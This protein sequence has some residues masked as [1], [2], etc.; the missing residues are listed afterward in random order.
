MSNSTVSDN[1]APVGGGLAND[2]NATGP[3]NIKNSI[4]AK[5]TLGDDCFNAAIFLA[6]GANLDTDGSCVAA[7]AS[8]NFAQVTSSQLNLGPLS[9]NAPGSTKTHALLSGSV[10]ID[11]ASDCTDFFNDPVTTDQRGVS[12]PQGMACD[13]GAYEREP[14]ALTSKVN[15]RFHYSANG[16]AGG[17]SGTKTVGPSGAVT[18]GPQAMGGNLIVQPG[19]TLRVGYDFTMPGSHPETTLAFTQTMVTFQALCA[20]G[21][22]GGT[23]V[24]SIQNRTYTDPQNSSA[25][26][27][28]GNQQDPSV[29]QASTI[30]PDFCGGGALS[31]REGAAFSSKVGSL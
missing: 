15:V 31:L 16:S 6:A 26:Y 3:M 13:I 11:A 2:S 19:N 22:G 1:S 21:S 23:I 17:W 20:S 18:I 7:A 25:W 30:V 9:L 8:T 4:V 28:S 29:Y 10:A 14:T 24:V 5:S 12:R 27:P